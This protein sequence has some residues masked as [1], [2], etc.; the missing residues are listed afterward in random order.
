MNKYSK[1]EIDRF[2]ERGKRNEMR[3]WGKFGCACR[4]SYHNYYPSHIMV[5]LYHLILNFGMVVI[6]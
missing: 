6:L 5:P 2:S 1:V 3:T 4:F